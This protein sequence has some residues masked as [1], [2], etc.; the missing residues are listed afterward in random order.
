[1]F[2][3]VICCSMAWGF[4]GPVGDEP[5]ASTPVLKIAG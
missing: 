1:M 3:V 5:V 4:P 2:L